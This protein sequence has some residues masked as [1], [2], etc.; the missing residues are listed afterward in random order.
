MAIDHYHALMCDENTPAMIRFYN[1]HPYCLSIGYHQNINFID[2]EKLRKEGFEFIRRPTG[3]KAIFHSDELTYSVIFPKR[4][5]DQ[6]RLYEFVHVLLARALKIL[7]FRVEL[8]TMNSRLPKLVNTPQEYP[9]F[10]TSAYSEIQY[11][12]KKLV[13]SAQRIYKKS[14]LQ[15]GSILIGNSHERLINFLKATPDQKQIILN[16]LKKK[17][18]CLHAIKNLAPSP[19]K[20]ALAIVKELESNECISVYSEPLNDK[21]LK[22]ARKI[23]DQQ[24]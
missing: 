10:S 3:G 16:N 15:H 9:C 21:E 11:K 18:T 1:W 12:H 17:T 2:H 7:G 20:L 23:W 14:I 8:A 19:D 6:T 4:L 22:N 5:F 24:M 13:G